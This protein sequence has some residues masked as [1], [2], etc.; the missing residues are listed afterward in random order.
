MN[1]STPAEA[2]PLANLVHEMR[3]QLAIA[4]ANVEAF[5]DGKIAPTAE[6]LEGVVQTLRVLDSLLTDVPSA[7]VMA[8]A[9]SRPREINVCS[10]LNREYRS[11]EA[12]AVER[13]V[14]FTVSRCPVATRECERFFG[15]P[16]RI[17][18][19]VSNVLINAVRYTPRGGSVAVACTRRADQLE[20]VI[21]DSG[22]GIA[23]D[24][25]QHVFEPG[26]RGAASTGS[27]GSGIGL[28]V[29]KEFVQ[30]QGGE[31][32]FVSSPRGTTFTIRLPGVAVAADGSQ[33]SPCAECQRA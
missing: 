14:T 33:M 5:I 8:P 21:A 12:I 10:L 18:Q 2:R 16:V 24:E 28:A 32:D 22:P 30:S 11:L 9:V 1:D 23:P 15:D 4:R 19:I 20:V 27:S 29:V 6:R 7:G 13:G 26:F 31:I 17:A 3:N 25:A